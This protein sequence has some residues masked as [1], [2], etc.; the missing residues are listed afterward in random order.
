MSYSDPKGQQN[1]FSDTLRNRFYFEAIQKTVHNDSIVMDL[2]AGLGLHGFMASSCGAKKTYLVEPTPILDISKKVVE[3]N[4]LAKKVECISGTIEKVALPEKVDVII[5]VFTGNFL[6]SE[7][8]LPSLFYARDK[9]L[10]PGGKMIPDR[11]TMVVA[12]VSSPDYYAEKIDFWLNPS[13]DIDYSSVRNYAAN[14][15]YYDGPKNRKSHFLAEPST[16]LELDFMTAKEAECRSK[17]EIE[18]TENGTMHGCLGWFDARVGDKWLSTSPVE[19]QMHWRQVF[20]PSNNP[21][22]V[23]K[24]D[25]ISFELIRPESGDWNWIFEY[26]G[27][28]QKH[29]TFLSHPQKMKELLKLANGYKG[30]LSQKGQV[31]QEAFKLMNGENTTKTII[32]ELVKKYPDYFTNE[33]EAVSFVKDIVAYYT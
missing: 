15:L 11:A 14:T 26:N 28:R 6:L 13:Y 23:Y 12:P 25:I 5:S 21:M 31:T 10:H 8:L 33:K 32:A 9:Y 18:I 22:N 29:S 4:G 27:K 17:I 3:A 19:E 2:G 24:G 1:M 30:N 20:L 7:D 16:L